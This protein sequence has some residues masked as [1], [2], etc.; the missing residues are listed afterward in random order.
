MLNQDNLIE[1]NKTKKEIDSIILSKTVL[2]ESINL[3]I[4]FLIND[5]EET[6]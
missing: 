3:R 4:E 1:D 5:I 2:L 6:K